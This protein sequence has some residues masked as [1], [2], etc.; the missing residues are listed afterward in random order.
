[1]M[2][3]AVQLTQGYPGLGVLSEH[4]AVTP[5]TNNGVSCFFLAL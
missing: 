1:M 4:L 2:L 3:Y 5:D